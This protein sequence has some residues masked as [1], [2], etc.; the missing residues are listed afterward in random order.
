MPNLIAHLKIFD[1]PNQHP[2]IC[3]VT[4]SKNMLKKAEEFVNR[5]P[6]PFGYATWSN[7]PA[8]KKQ[9]FPWANVP[10]NLRPVAQ[11][12]FNRKIQEWKDSGRPL[13][14]G[15]I[16]SLRCIAT[17]VAKEF[18]TGKFGAR[19]KWWNRYKKVWREHLAELE[20]KQKVAEFKEKPVKERVKHLPL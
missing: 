18:H 20:E 11:E 8:Y 15:K 3:A 7:N 16:N 2:Y 9:P 14:W 13:T 12:W 1:K 6:K 4:V 5:K 19:G 17:R 10:E